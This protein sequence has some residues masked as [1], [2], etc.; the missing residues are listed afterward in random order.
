M[1]LLYIAFSNDA[2]AEK[3]IWVKGSSTAQANLACLA[4]WECRPEKDILYSADSK[5]TATQPE[6]TVGVC[7]AAGG[8]I[9]GCNE[10]SSSPPT[11]PCEWKL[12]KK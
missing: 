12:E 10:C 6:Y 8:D 1:L 3:G 4:K 7:N 9:E 11:Q 5:I 2:M